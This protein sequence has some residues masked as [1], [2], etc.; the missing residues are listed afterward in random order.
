MEAGPHPLVGLQA[1]IVSYSEH[2][3][4]YLC[5]WVNVTFYLSF[6]LWVAVYK[7]LKAIHLLHTDFQ[8][9]EESQNHGAPFHMIAPPV[10]FCL[11]LHPFIKCFAMALHSCRL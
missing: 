4:M 5:M 1:H 6:L 3:S 10:Y 9:T 2:S 8:P 7:S 11:V